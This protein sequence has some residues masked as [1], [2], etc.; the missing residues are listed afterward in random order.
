MPHAPPPA[1]AERLARIIDLLCRAVAARSAGGAL[2]GP[3][4]ILIWGHLR[5][6]A[7]RIFRLAARLAAG[8]KPASPRIQPARPTRPKPPQR[9]PRGFAW[10]VRLVPE[11]ASGAAQLQHLLAEPEMA[12]LL[13]SPQMGRLLRPL[14]RM[15]GVTPPPEIAKPPPVTPA[16]PARAT[17]RAS[18]PVP[19][20]R[21]ASPPRVGPAACGPPVAA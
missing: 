6:R 12:P 18:P 2:A 11:T 10:L 20:P 3:F 4:I 1:P 8:T 5:R 14:C 16:A 17:P 9:L 7:S 19:P 15:L 21:P 13:A